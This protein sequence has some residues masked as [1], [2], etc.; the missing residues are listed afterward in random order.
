MGVRKKYFAAFAI[1][2]AV[3]FFVQD[4]HSFWGRS[5]DRWRQRMETEDI[6]GTPSTVTKPPPVAATAPTVGDGSLNCKVGVV[7]LDKNIESPSGERVSL[8]VPELKHGGTKDFACDAVAPKL[9]NNDGRVVNAG[10]I[11]VKCGNGQV[12]V[13]AANCTAPAATPAAPPPPPPPANVLPNGCPVGFG[14]I[15]CGACCTDTQA[16]Y[17]YRS[18]TGGKNGYC[19]SNTITYRSCKNGQKYNVNTRSCL[20]SFPTSPKRC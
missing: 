16:S 17:S 6:K 10:S 18:F 2:F 5:K 20:S 19:R 8:A 7:Y 3:G 1:L 15:A 4:T 13:S 14:V 9:I 12:F 11:Q